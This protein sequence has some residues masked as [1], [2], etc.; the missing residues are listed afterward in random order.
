MLVAQIYTG[1]V[2]ELMNRIG[3]LGTSSS[4]AF[5]NRV[6]RM[7][8]ERLTGQPAP[9]DT[10]SFDG[11]LYDLG[12]D[13]ERQLDAGAAVSLPSA[14]Y[15]I[16]LINAVKFHCG[17]MFHL[18]DEATFMRHFH[19]FH[20]DGLPSGRGKGLWFIHYLMILAFGKAFVA[21]HQNARR[22]PGV[23][24]FVH[25]LKL[26]PDIT[27]LIY[28]PLQAVEILCCKALYLQCLD[29]RCAGYNVV[30]ISLE[31]PFQKP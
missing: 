23:D 21:R 4:W 18:F 11:T 28:D 5:T 29:Y 17:Q 26:M 14:D 15:A 31:H 7:A 25:A 20:Q 16:Y 30:S 10:I 8:H 3:H 6:L 9:P 19:D 12:W 22:P 27:F 2:W 24:L 1:V 13:G